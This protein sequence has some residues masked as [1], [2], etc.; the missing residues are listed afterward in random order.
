MNDSVQ[1]LLRLAVAAFCGGVLGLN[2]GTFYSVYLVVGGVFL[3]A[4]ATRRSQHKA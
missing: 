2:R 4:L 3:I 1:L